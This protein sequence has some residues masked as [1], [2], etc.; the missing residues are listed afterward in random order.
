MM[1]I[2][3][4]NGTSKRKVVSDF[5]KQTL[6]CV[7]FSVLFVRIFLI[8]KHTSTKR[9]RQRQRQKAKTATKKC[10]ST[11]SQRSS[12]GG[13]K[14]VIFHILSRT[15]AY[16]HG[17]WTHLAKELRAVECASWCNRCVVHH[18]RS[19]SIAFVPRAERVRDY[20]W[21]FIIHSTYLFLIF[22][23]VE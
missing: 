7:I 10:A 16:R 9:R 22:W 2:I 23:F 5:S 19:N 21:H 12:F 6:F 3:I 8:V 17:R 4:I 15:S 14:C 18:C 1:L 13:N 20:E 11:S